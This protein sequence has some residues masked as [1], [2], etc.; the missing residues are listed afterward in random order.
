[1]DTHGLADPSGTQEFADAAASATF[2]D[3]LLRSAARSGIVSKKKCLVPLPFSR[4]SFEILCDGQVRVFVDGHKTHL[5]SLS[6]DANCRAIHREHDVRAVEAAQLRDAE[7]C[8]EEKADHRVHAVFARRELEHA[9]G[10]LFRQDGRRRKGHSLLRLQ[11]AA[12]R[13]H[14]E[15]ESYELISP[16]EKSA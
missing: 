1:M 11:S 6:V 3:S 8:A 10:F 15:R 14:G 2:A 16:P 12:S 5:V 4:R 13:F 9:A 7:A